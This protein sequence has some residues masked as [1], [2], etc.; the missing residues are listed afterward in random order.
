VTCHA[1]NEFL[2]LKARTFGKSAEL[3][4]IDVTAA[5][6][7]TPADST[8]AILFDLLVALRVHA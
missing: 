8:S 7:L 1:I 4:F 3:A 6:A 2:D 5:T